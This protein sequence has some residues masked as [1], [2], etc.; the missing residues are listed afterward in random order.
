MKQGRDLEAGLRLDRTG[1]HN[2][3]LGSRRHKIFARHVLKRL[4]RTFHNERSE[5]SS[6]GL[7]HHDLGIHD[8]AIESKTTALNVRDNIA[9]SSAASQP[10]A[11]ACCSVS[12]RHRSSVAGSYR[13]RFIAGAGCRLI[14]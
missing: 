4:N 10:Q 7:I 12:F 6:S 2:C 3:W 13:E 9:L 1:W 5:Q 8:Q 14:I 11:I